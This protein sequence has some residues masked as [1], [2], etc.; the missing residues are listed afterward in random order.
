VLPTATDLSYFLAVVDTLNIRRAAER[1]RIA[2][3]S[4]STAMQRLEVAIGSPLLTRTNSGVQLTRAGQRLVPKIRALLDE[5]EK[6]CSEAAADEAEIRGRYV[7]GCPEGVALYT[8]PLALPELLRAHSTLEIEFVH[9]GSYRITDDVITGKIDFGIVANPARHPDLVIKRICSD[10]VRMWVSGSPDRTQDPR[11]GEAVL[12]SVPAFIDLGQIRSAGVSFARTITTRSHH[13]VATLV[14]AGIG[15]G[16]LP[17][18]VAALFSTSGIRPLPR[19]MFHL[20]H[21]ICFVYRSDAHR[22]LGSRRLA[23]EIEAALQ[24]ALSQGNSHERSASRRR[25]LSRTKK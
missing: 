14:A 6:V 3:P 13:V 24:R 2:Q 11:S 7:L 25:S 8:L 10:E 18:R 22:L 17:G 4:L 21:E 5:W 16:I 1:L 20:E 19:E 23:Q 12:V 9:G 15:I